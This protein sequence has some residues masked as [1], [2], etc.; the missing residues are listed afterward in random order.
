M[1]FQAI[2]ALLETGGVPMGLL[3]LVGWLTRENRRLTD[4]IIT[5]VGERASTAAYT[6]EFLARIL[7]RL[8]AQ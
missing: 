2:W 5:E 8:N 1:D 4:I 7:D 6:K 3:I